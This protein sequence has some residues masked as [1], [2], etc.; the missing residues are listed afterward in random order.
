MELHPKVKEV[1]DLLCS[2]TY[3]EGKAFYCKYNNGKIRFQPIS[4]NSY[5][6]SITDDKPSGE[7]IFDDVISAPLIKVSSN[8]EGVSEIELSPI[9]TFTKVNG[10]YNLHVDS[11]VLHIDNSEYM[12]V[13][14]YKVMI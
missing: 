5:H 2:E 4:E 13:P 1:A 9:V 3:E 8:K 14:K 10:H 6:I 11:A 12:K 7:V